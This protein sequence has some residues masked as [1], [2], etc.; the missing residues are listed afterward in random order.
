MKHF[1]HRRAQGTLLA[2]QHYDREQLH[3]EKLHSKDDQ[4]ISWALPRMLGWFLLCWVTLVSVQGFLLL[5]GSQPFRQFQG[6]LCLATSPQQGACS[7]TIIFVTLHDLPHPVILTLFTFLMVLQGIG[8]WVGLAGK[9][10]QPLFWL[11]FLLQGV[12][13]LIVCLIAQQTYLALSLYLALLLGALGML[14]HVRPMLIILCFYSVL[15]LSFSYASFVSMQILYKQG[16]VGSIPS[17]DVTNYTA[18]ILFVIGY[19]LLYVQQ[20]HAHKRIAAYA[21]RVEE[22]TR[23]TERQR[24]ARELHDTLSQGLVGLSLQ[25]DAVDAL[26]T[27]QRPERAQEV[28]RQAMERARSTLA[29]TRSSLDT[30][31]AEG[32]P[33]STGAVL[34]ERLHEQVAHFTGGTGLACKVALGNLAELPSTLHEP[35]LRMITEGL[36]NV[37]RHA[38]A[39]QVEICICQ[40]NQEVKIDVC[41]DGVGFD[42][43]RIDRETGHYGLLGLRERARSLGGQMCIESVAGKGSRL[44]FTIP[45][46]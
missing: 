8:F 25:L 41:D 18:F 15:L 33:A 36:T 14:K 35:V 40:Q 43:T 24:L 20:L 16:L 34:A 39:Q 6:G 26:L 7:L 12:L 27:R 42:P 44:R 46:A 11:F 22:L 29:E 30:L 1:L 31:R 38:Q 37:A 4:P 19:L 9:V 23:L 32:T 17:W 13:F 21:T 5:A 45:L 3:A 10:R 28:V 2:S